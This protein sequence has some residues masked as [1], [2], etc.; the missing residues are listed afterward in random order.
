[1]SGEAGPKPGSAW[2][3]A[4]RAAGPKGLRRLGVG[5]RLLRFHSARSGAARGAAGKRQQRDVARALDGDAEPAL[6]TCADAGHAAGQD[7]AALLTELGKNVG[8]LVVDQVHLF[9]TELADLLFAEKLAL[10]A[11]TSAGTARAAF[12]ASAAGRAFAARTGVTALRSRRGRRSLR[13]GRRCGCLILF[14]CHS[15]YPFSCQRL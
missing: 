3:S 13:R 1:T 15:F 7:L 2:N 14:V 8:A 11:R 6:V 5:L 4:N 12:T 9:D 10:S